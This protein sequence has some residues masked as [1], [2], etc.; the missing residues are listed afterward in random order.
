MAGNLHTLPRREVRVD[1][2]LQGVQFGLLIGDLSSEFVAGFGSE[3]F[4]HLLDFFAKFDDGFFEFQNLFHGGQER[5]GRW[6][7]HEAQL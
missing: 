4:L 5:G 1:V 2:T 3:L 6:L 7:A